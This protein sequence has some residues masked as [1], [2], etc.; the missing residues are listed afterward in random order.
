M[1]PRGPYRHLDL[2]TAIFI[3]ALL[4][5]NLVASKTASL[6]GFTVGVGIFVFPISYIFGDVLTEVYGYRASRR[7]IWLGFGAGGLAATIFLLC[8]VAPP[9]PGYLHQAA[10]HT[11]LGQSPLILAASLTAYWAGEFCNSYVL[12]RMKVWSGGRHLWMRTIGSTVVG[13][14]VDSLLFYPL[15]FALLPRALGFTAAVWPTQ[16]VLEVMLGN[17]VLKVLFEDRKSVV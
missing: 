16:L 17:Y 13:E 9:A 10:F 14:G 12:A 1:N 5:S 8:D 7:V 2:I 11:I 3:T 6:L 15:A 4:S